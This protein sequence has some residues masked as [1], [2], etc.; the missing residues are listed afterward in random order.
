MVTLREFAS[1]SGQGAP[2]DTEVADTVIARLTST[3]EQRAALIDQRLAARR[4]GVEAIRKARTEL[5][6]RSQI[7]VALEADKGALQKNTDAL[8]RAN[9]VRSDGQAIRGKVEQVRVEII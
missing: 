3:L 4:A 2:A 1:A 5:A 6:R 7:D 9:A 8:A